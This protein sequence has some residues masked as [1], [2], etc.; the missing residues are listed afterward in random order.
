MPKMR[1]NS[2]SKKRFKKTATGKLKRQKAFRSH[3]LTKKN[4]K[5]KRD[6]RQDA[7]LHPADERRIMRMLGM[8]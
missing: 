3:I 2:S 4:R 5:R 6:L 8:A 7:I 1:T